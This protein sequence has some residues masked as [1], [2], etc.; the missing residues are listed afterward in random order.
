MTSA[1]PSTVQDTGDQQHTPSSQELRERMVAELIESGMLTDPNIEEAFRAVPRE[2]FCPPGTPLEAPYA[3]HDVVH[4]REDT[5]GVVLSSVSAPYMQAENLA[6]LRVEPGMRVLEI[7]S[8]PMA[9]M[10][11]H[12]VGPT[13][14][15]VS[16]DI[17]PSVTDRVRAGLDELGLPADVITADAGQ[18]L[19]RGVFDRII[20]TAAAWTIPP[21]WLEQLAGDGVLVVPLRLAP[22]M[23]RI[24]GFVRDGDHLR[25]ESVVLGGFVSMQGDH[26]HTPPAVELAGP[27]G[28]NV[29]FTFAETV[30]E[31]F[32][33]DGAVLASEP[34]ESWSTVTYRNGV[35]WVDILS[36]VLLQP[37]GCSITAE[38]KSDLGHE[39]A[40]FPALI[41]GDSYAAICWRPHPDL[42]EHV[43]VGA[44][45]KGPGAQELCDRLRDALEQYDHHHRGSDPVYRYWPARSDQPDDPAP[46]FAVRHVLPRPHGLITIDWPIHLSAPGD[47][48]A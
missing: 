25:A 14:Q 6:Q 5:D 9:A 42:D 37:G 8:G 24:L 11:A 20:V 3:I 47:T 44:V 33:V 28:G 23:Q 46:E 19:G 35:V 29:V 41:E 7:G 16:V 43:Q 10:L 40:F 34:A 27:S 21:V 13:G 48:A 18:P 22:G 32:A 38:E 2:V 12:L 15:V 1:T 45:G 30:P 26:Q 31:G 36:W 4:T 17:D 39:R